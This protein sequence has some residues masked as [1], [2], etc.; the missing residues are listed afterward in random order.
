MDLFLPAIVAFALSCIAVTVAKPIAI[1]AGLVDVPNARKHHDGH[2][3]LVGGI[4][5]FIAVLFAVMIFLPKSQ[6]INIFLLSAALIVFIGVLDDKYD[7]KVSFRL[8]AQ[9]LAACMMIFGAGYYLENL[10]NL[11]GLGDIHLGYAG[12]VLTVIAVIGAINAFNMVDGIDG[13]AGSLSVVSFV[14]LAVLFGLVNSPWTVVPV[15]F[16]GAVLA[17]LMFNLGW[18]SKR[19]SKVFMGDAGSMLIGLSV[20][21]M[22]VIGTQSSH[23]A[24]K[25][26]TALW[27]IAM[28]LMDMTAIMV[29]RIMKRQSP[30][31]PDRDHLHHIFMRAGFSPRQA[32]AIIIVKALC[33][34]VLGILMEYYRVAESYSLLCF[35]II[36]ATYSWSINHIW[37]VVTF[38]RKVRT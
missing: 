1:R 6:A 15:L 19:V 16:V 33:L 25:P 9:A 3:P 2:I 35:L 37:Q 18:P 10:G 36:F 12:I 28:P 4:A 14:S 23:T 5:I 27:I 13:L 38:I 32:L 31:K 26:V 11:V 17:Y 29:R 24:F 8:M 30:F 22:L 21:W 7:L 20:V 34:A